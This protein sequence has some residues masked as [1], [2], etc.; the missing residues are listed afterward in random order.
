MRV[1]ILDL[2]SSGRSA[3][4]KH[5]LEDYLT[6]RQYASVMPQAIAV[7][8]RQLGHKV[9][10]ATF[11]GQTDPKRQLPDGLDMV[12]IAGITMSAP[13]SYA[14]AKLWRQENTVTVAGGPHAKSFP[15]PA[16]LRLGGDPVRQATYRRHTQWRPRARLHSIQRAGPGG[17]TQR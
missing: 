16:V 1:G 10:Y 17:Y 3:S 9:F 12:F 8:C 7:W 4:R 6:T 2:L 15:L 11:Y 13:L 14:L 5:A